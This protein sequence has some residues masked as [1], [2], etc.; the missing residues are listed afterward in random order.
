MDLIKLSID[1]GTNFHLVISPV[2]ICSLLLIV[3]IF[4]IYRR[5]VLSKDYEI[6]EAELGIGNTKIK[7]RPNHEDLQVGYKLLVELSTRKIG[8]PIDAEHDVIEE[9]YDSWYEFF[10]ITRELIKGIPAV[11]IRRSESTRN[12]VKISTEVLN[13]GVRPHLTMWQARFRRWYDLE[14][15]SDKCIGLS[16]QEVQKRFPEYQ[17]LFADMQK[18]NKTLIKYKTILEAMVLVKEA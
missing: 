7:I 12:L 13:H 14:L 10:R 15:K 6:D 4:L 3:L 11:K 8:L 9:V 17:A 16:P 5:C 1:S 2:L 18:I